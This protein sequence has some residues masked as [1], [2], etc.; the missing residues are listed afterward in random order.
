MKLTKKK[1]LVTGVVL[2]HILILSGALSVLE[3]NPIQ[4]L[5]KMHGM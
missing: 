4:F 5:L 3:F 1:W 2:L